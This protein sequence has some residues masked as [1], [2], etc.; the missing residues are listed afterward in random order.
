[1]ARSRGST[2]R[3]GTLAQDQSHHRRNPLATHGRSIHWVTSGPRSRDAFCL[4][5]ARRD[6]RRLHS[7][8]RPYL[9]G[10]EGFSCGSPESSMSKSGS[11]T[12][13]PC[14]P[15]KAGWALIHSLGCMSTAIPSDKRDHLLVAA[16]WLRQ[17][18]RE[19]HLLHE[20]RRSDLRSRL[21]QGITCR[22][23]MSARLPASLEPYF[24]AAL[25]LTGLANVLAR[26]G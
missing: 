14:S 26:A 16:P 5:S 21:L 4:L 18:A 19:D 8:L 24:F 7:A 23:I 2:N 20:G 11:K 17:A 1:M 3:P 12:V 25:V 15:R 6:I 10:N 9:G 13:L 22:A